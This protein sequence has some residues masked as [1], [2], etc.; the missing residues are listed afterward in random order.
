M[1]ALCMVTLVKEAVQVT[2]GFTGKEFHMTK[3]PLSVSVTLI[4]I[5]LNALVWLALGLIIALHAHPALPD[6]PILQ[7]EMALLS[8]CAAGILLGLFIFLGKRG[9]LA[10]FAA[11]G[12]LAF[13]SILTIFDDFGWTDLIVLVIN[14]VPIILLI[15]DRAWYLQG[16][17]AAA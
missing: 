6:N 15:K 8:F 1:K 13:T 4:F 3:R 16:K 17:P 5:I 9:R 14:I 12:C 2:L 7:A 11:L 10:W